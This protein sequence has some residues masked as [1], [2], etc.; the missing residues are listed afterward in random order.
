[1]RRHDQV[2]AHL[3]KIAVFFRACPDRMNNK[4]LQKRTRNAH[5]LLVKFLN[6][7]RG[8]QRIG[9]QTGIGDHAFALLADEI[10]RIKLI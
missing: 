6:K 4:T 7:H 10:K 8:E 9:D 2:A 5:F 3:A 1:M